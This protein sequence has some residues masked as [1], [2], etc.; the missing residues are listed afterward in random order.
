M[1]QLHSI[2]TKDINATNNDSDQ[3]TLLL[4][5]LF[6][7]SGLTSLHALHN[8]RRLAHIN[9]LSTSFMPSLQNNETIDT[10]RNGLDIVDAMFHHSLRREF[11]FIPTS[12]CL[13]HG[14]ALDELLH[15]EYLYIG[16]GN[17]PNKTWTCAGY[18][19]M[20]VLTFLNIIE[21]LHNLYV[22][23]EE[24]NPA[25]KTEFLPYIN[26]D[27]RVYNDVVK[28]IFHRN[29]FQLDAPQS[30]NAT[31][32]DLAR[33]VIQ[34]ALC[35]PAHTRQEDRFG[36]ETKLSLKNGDPPLLYHEM[37][38]TIE[39]PS[40][41]DLVT[42]IKPQDQSSTLFV[43]Y[44]Q[45]NVEDPSL[46]GVLNYNRLIHRH[47]LTDE[48]IYFSK[49]YGELMDND[50]RGHIFIHYG[51]FNMNDNDG[52]LATAL[53]I[54]SDMDLHLASTCPDAYAR[55]QEGGH[56]SEVDMGELIESLGQMAIIHYQ[57]KDGL[58]LASTKGMRKVIARH[59]SNNMDSSD[60]VKRLQ[61]LVD[62]KLFN[63]YLVNHYK[64][65]VY[66]VTKQHLSSWLSPLLY[67]MMDIA[68]IESA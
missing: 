1:S 60:L 47:N 59:L 14:L 25:G 53:S 11:Q 23:A 52:Q 12:S 26:S 40:R 34:L 8:L 10:I 21:Q 54:L 36:I 7:N 62:S 24:V 66:V 16:N 5:G 15:K 64:K 4:K 58:K 61:A 13:V 46:C 39:A 51:A 2:A 30:N 50:F 19:Q 41:K 42:M 63:N 56:C 29:L 32:S 44:N 65:R 67:N 28:D 6:E 31:L 37:I 18:P 57:F 45:R 20:T 68:T 48:Y 22:S 49:I 33:S 55:L 43:R 9:K 27:E 3:S 17:D 35:L 38:N